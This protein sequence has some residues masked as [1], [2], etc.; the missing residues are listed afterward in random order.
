MDRLIL[1]KKLIKVV[2]SLLIHYFG[3]NIIILDKLDLGLSNV[4]I[5]YNQ[6]LDSFVRPLN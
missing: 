3:N 4:L 2:W 5:N 6:K 1:K